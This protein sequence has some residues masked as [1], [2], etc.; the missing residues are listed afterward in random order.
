MEDNKNKNMIETSSVSIVLRMYIDVKGKCMFT[1]MVFIKYC[2]F[3]LI[4]K[5]ILHS[6][7]SRFPLGVRV[8]T[9]YTWL[10]MPEPLDGWSNTSAA[11]ELAE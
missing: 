8:C 3:F 5:Y 7:L 11:A 2:I 1:Y 9:V 4:L 10:N 6:G